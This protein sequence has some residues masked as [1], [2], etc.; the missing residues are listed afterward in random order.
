M[1][2]ILRYLGI[3][4]CFLAPVHA[5]IVQFKLDNGLKVTIKPNYRAP[6]AIVMIWY[7]V[8]SADE[9]PGLTG[10]SHMLEHMM[11]KGT[12]AVPND[13]FT[14]IIAENGGQMN[15]FTAQDYTAY[16]EKI[17]A[18]SIDI[19]L[20]LEAD[21]MQ[22]LQLTEQDFAKE[23][24]VVK[25]ER[26]L[27]IE[28]NPE[29]ITLERLNATAYLSFA[30]QH[31]VIGWMADLSQINLPALKKW[32]KRYYSPNNANLIIVGA[33]D[34]ITIQ[35]KIEHYFGK[36]PSKQLPKRILQQEPQ[37]LGAKSVNISKNA[38]QPIMMMAFAA[39]SLRYIELLNATNPKE[40]QINPKTPYV[41]EVIAGIL[42]AGD[43]GR[44]NQELVN[45]Q[46]VAAAANAFYDLYSL[47]ATQFIFFAVPS[48]ASNLEEVKKAILQ[49]INRLKTELV[50]AKELQRIKTQLI[51]QKT[52]AEDSLFSQASELGIVNSI[53]LASKVI[54]AYR[55]QIEAVTN[56]EIRECANKYFSQSA[57]TVAQLQPS[58]STRK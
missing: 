51:A 36:I 27:R 7:E 12:K 16:Y 38:E 52:Y 10:L 44:L 45:K 13:Q 33:V 28:D 40:A 15:A 1:K 23:L 8:G 34:P 11:F 20:R 37:S 39:P 57:L 56:N 6:I 32:Y 3:I 25:E 31:P 19:P 55:T 17:A 42:D 50:S 43:N 5:D 46:H 49:Q 4:F 22:N 18:Q 53:G 9:P 58:N 26:R 24:N 41:L 30:Y 14:K 35:R 21:R 2:Q 48:A 47:L 29:A 54:D